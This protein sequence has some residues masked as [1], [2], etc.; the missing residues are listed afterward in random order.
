MTSQA[1][2]IPPPRVLLVLFAVIA[3]A[4][5]ATSASSSSSSSTV[6]RTKRVN[7]FQIL[8]GHTVR[9]QYR[10][11]LPHTYV[12]VSQLPSQFSWENVNGT[13]YL[14][15]ILNQHLPQYCGSCWAHG[16]LSALADRIKI[17]RRARGPDINLSIQYVLNCGSDIAG[18]CHGGSATGV[19]QFLYDNPAVGIPYDT[20]QP[21]LACSEESTEGFC[22][23]VSTQCTSKAI[24]S[25]C[26]S[27]S[28][29]PFRGKC[30]PVSYSSSIT[31]ISSI[32]VIET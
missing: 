3:V 30:T 8:P 32:S 4:A 13:S 10:L 7:E 28:T 24:C 25:T 12:D 1:W 26:N 22:P 20:C 11:P 6:T 14:T 15:H 21:Y 16:A 29:F 19:Y 9:N 17:S 5:S 27:F 2:F 31:K 23:H 18:S